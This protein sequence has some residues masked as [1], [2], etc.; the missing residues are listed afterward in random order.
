MQWIRVS[1][2]LIFLAGCYTPEKAIKQSNKAIDKHP[3]QVLPL[4]RAKFPCDVIKVDTSIIYTDTIINFD[5]PNEPQYIVN[6]DTVYRVI[7]KP[8]VVTVYKKVTLPSKVITKY[9]KDSSLVRELQLKLLVCETNY[10]VDS[11]ELQKVNLGIKK[12]NYWIFSLILLLVISVLTNF[13]RR[14]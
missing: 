3:E 8:K 6:D 14:R 5:C 10:A 9:I 11:K 2:I 12:R 4:F 13:I 1:S 7:Y